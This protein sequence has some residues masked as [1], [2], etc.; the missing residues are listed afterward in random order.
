MMRAPRSASCL[1]ANGAATACSTD[2]TVMPCNGSIKKGTAPCLRASVARDR[3]VP[4]LCEDCPVMT[5]QTRATGAVVDFIA[6][7]T[8]SDIPTDALTIGRRCIADGVAAILAGS[9]TAASE[10]LR[11]QVRED[12]SRA[13]S[14]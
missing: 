9:T 2:T 7:A 8:F 4:Q 14:T 13:E 1:V 11:A 5:Q 6:S 12:D 3:N 10:I